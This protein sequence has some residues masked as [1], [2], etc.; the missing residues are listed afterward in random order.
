MTDANE[1]ADEIK[2]S[3]N[4][5]ESSSKGTCRTNGRGKE[6]PQTLPEAYRRLSRRE[7][8]VL[9]KIAEGKSNREIAGELFITKGTVENHITRIGK[10]LGVQ[11]RG[12]VRQWVD[13]LKNENEQP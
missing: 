12:S 9:E 11:G 10:V 2:E 4:L 7:S 13:R 1:R 5:S 6:G 8:E 3:E